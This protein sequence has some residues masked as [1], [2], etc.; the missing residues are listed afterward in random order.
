MPKCKVCGK[1]LNNPNSKRHLNSKY[2]LQKL[3]KSGKIQKSIEVKPEVRLRATSEIS[4]LRVI[5]SDLEKRLSM[6]EKA[7]N[8]K[9]SKMKSRKDLPISN[10]L[11]IENLIINILNQKSNQQQIRG[12]FILK[13]IRDI[14]KKSYN[15]PESKFEES[16]LRLYRKQLVD[17]QPGGNPED[18]HLLSPTGKKFYYLIAKLS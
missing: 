14:L 4:E 2:H 17:L 6:V 12:N 3:G 10:E 13:N 1:E 9:S 5:I 18:Y 7:L 16:V 8:I 11:D 15:V